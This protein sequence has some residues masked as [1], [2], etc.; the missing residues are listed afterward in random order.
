MPTDIALL[1]ALIDLADL[2]IQLSNNKSDQKALKSLRKVRNLLRSRLSTNSVFNDKQKKYVITKALSE[3]KKLID[4]INHL[5]KKEKIKKDPTL[6]KNILKFE[7]IKSKKLKEN[8]DYELITAELD[9]IKNRAESM[10]RKANQLN[11]KNRLKFLDDIKNEMNEIQKIIKDKQKETDLHLEAYKK[12]F[13]KLKTAYIS[14]KND[15]SVI[16]KIRD[17]KRKIY[18]ISKSIIE[19][20]HP[21]K[22]L[23][24]EIQLILKDAPIKRGR[25]KGGKNGSHLTKNK[26]GIKKSQDIDL[27]LKKAKKLA[28]IY[29]SKLDQASDKFD[30]NTLVL[31]IKLR[32]RAHSYVNNSSE[33]NKKTRIEFLNELCDKIDFYKTK[34]KKIENSKASKS[35][36]KNS[37]NFFVS[38]SSS[39]NTSTKEDDIWVFDPDLNR[40][41]KVTK[42]GKRSKKILTIENVN[43]TLNE[44]KKINIL[45]GSEECF[46]SSTDKKSVYHLPSRFIFK[47]SKKHKKYMRTIQYLKKYKV[48]LQ[49]NQQITLKQ[50]FK[51]ISPFN[52]KNIINIILLS[53]LAFSLTKKQKKINKSFKPKINL[54]KKKLNSRYKKLVLKKSIS[55]SNAKG[56]N[57][58]YSHKTSNTNIK[59]SLRYRSAKRH[60]GQS[61]SWYRKKY[62][63]QYSAAGG[64]IFPGGTS[65]QS[66]VGKK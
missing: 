23:L 28:S 24:K 48:K 19:E 57:K 47:N 52:H 58:S 3:S 56:L 2:C 37:S 1:K 25:K 54:L 15:Y 10:Y 35:Q 44:L 61:P 26:K 53:G 49:S 34:K 66:V 21:R 22:K 46:E 18:D 20:S 14:N 40:M 45:D 30:Q 43:K 13:E 41:V 11:K 59:K 5:N 7:E 51:E 31:L 50:I 63:E 38:N 29:Y 17:L 32:K 64:F 16:K 9:I 60:L 4:H 27:T 36:I 33:E 55:K 12:E 8:P 6:Q 42:D 65:A 62:R 39:N